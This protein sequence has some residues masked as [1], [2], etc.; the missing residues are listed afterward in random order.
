MAAQFYVLDV[1]APPHATA[2]QRKQTARF[3][4]KWFSHDRIQSNLLFRNKSRTHQGAP[5]PKRLRLRLSA[6]INLF[7]LKNGFNFRFRSL[8]PAE[9]SINF[10]LGEPGEHKDFTNYFNI[11]LFSKQVN[12][13]YIIDVVCSKTVRGLGARSTNSSH[14]IEDARQ[15]SYIRYCLY[16][17]LSFTKTICLSADSNNNLRR[18]RVVS[19]WGNDEKLFQ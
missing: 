17:R 10:V 19:E 3:P 4:I 16:I 8:L 7:P 14:R 2:Q 5:S 9:I 6:Q 13:F 12:G 1:F 15:R 18:E 11:L